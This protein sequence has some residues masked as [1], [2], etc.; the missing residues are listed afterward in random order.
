MWKPSN[1]WLPN[2]CLS[3]RKTNQEGT[4]A[5]RKIL[6]DSLKKWSEKTSEG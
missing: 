4:E 5:V 6:Q 1:Q 2:W 3:D